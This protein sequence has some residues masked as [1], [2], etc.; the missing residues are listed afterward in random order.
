M[1]AETTILSRV[2]GAAAVAAL[3]NRNAGALL[4][5]SEELLGEHLRRC[6]MRHVR[7][8][9]ELSRAEMLTQPHF[10]AKDGDV[11]VDIY[12]LS[13][14]SMDSPAGLS[15]EQC[16]YCEQQRGRAVY[17]LPCVVQN[18]REGVARCVAL[19]PVELGRNG[20]WHSSPAV[21]QYLPLRYA[22]AAGVSM[23]C[24]AWLL[25]KSNVL[26][27]VAN[28]GVRLYPLVERFAHAGHLPE[29]TVIRASG[30]QSPLMLTL[31]S[32]REGGRLQLLYGDF[33]SADN[34]VNELAVKE[35]PVSENEPMVRLS[36]KDGSEFCAV[37]AELAMFPDHEWQGQ[38]FL[39]A[40]S[41]LCHRMSRVPASEQTSFGYENGRLCAEVR[42]ARRSSLRDLPLCHLEVVAGEQTFNVY[43]AV[44][45]A[46]AS[47]PQPGDVVCAEGILYAV[48]EALV[49]K[50]APMLPQPH[51]DYL[52]VSVP[53][54]VV[55]G[56][57]RAA[58]YT[59][60]TPYKPLFRSGVPELRL[61]SP[62]GNK[63]WVL[64]DTVV[65]GTRDSN[66]YFRYAPD[67]YPEHVKG[68]ADVLFASV[69]LTGTD[70]GYR[71]S[72]SLHGRVPAGLTFCEDVKLPAVEALPEVTAARVFGEMMV[73]HD[74]SALLPLLKDDVCYKS[75]TAGLHLLGKFDLLRHLR[76]CFDNWQ[77]RGECANLSF[78]LSSVEVNGSRRPCVLACQRGEIISATVFDVAEGRIVSVESMAGDVLDTIQP[79]SA[80]EP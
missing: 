38:R 69:A 65:N 49:E 14:G 21:L 68:E 3:S 5:E 35:V 9:V 11:P 34:A 43:A 72:V 28:N 62:Q 64:L 1:Q 63:I 42:S 36:A 80:E 78:L 51:E 32:G 79:L 71:T 13:I 76:A 26:R 22:H 41:M 74:F 52:S 44:Y 29:D 59:M 70:A 58:G 24:S 53:L 17:V 8:M 4:A 37:C 19:P 16:R 2:E 40:L 15:D 18:L 77:R 23:P 31:V 61:K 47:L 7:R 75:D 66:G 33:Y 55:A 50:K 6:A 30:T 12:V 45:D 48:P 25:K 46:E 60:E 56:G 57:L 10:T 73:T 39:W 54:A 27:E 67:S 20:A